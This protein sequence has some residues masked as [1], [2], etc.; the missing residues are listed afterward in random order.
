MDALAHVDG[1][2]LPLSQARIP[3]D[4]RGHL[5]GDGLFETMRVHHGAVVARA[6]HLQRL[7]RGMQVLGLEADVEPTIDALAHAAPEAR[8]RI[9]VTRGRMDGID[10]G[11]APSVTG[12]ATDFQARHEPVH[13]VTSAIR[14]Q[15]D[16]PLAGLKLLSFQPYLH[17]RREAR[18]AGV[19]DA[20]LLNDA[21]R[22]AEASTSNV[23]ALV[24]GQVH[25][26]GPAEGA[27]DGVTRRRLL[28]GME[29][30]HDSLTPE[31]LRRGEAVLVNTSGVRPIAS[32]DGH[33]LDRTAWTQTMQ[34]A[35]A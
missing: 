24:D 10:D 18:A 22:V 32:V 34:E 5:L 11:T 29:R 25:A 26:P 20:L 23:I 28:G 1:R 2:I 12:I 7:R 27:I 6:L 3:L 9:Q 15:R 16:S 14:L 17:A 30:V 19:D 35:W 4:D 21:N 13:L 33:R 31:A 8:L